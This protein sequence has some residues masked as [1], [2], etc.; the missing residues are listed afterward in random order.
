MKVREIIA[1]FLF[2]HV[3]QTKTYA[4]ERLLNITEADIK[5]IKKEV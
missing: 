3:F 5:A 2:D 4:E 1:K